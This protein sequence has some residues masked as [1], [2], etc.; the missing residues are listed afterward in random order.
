[1]TSRTSPAGRLVIQ[2]GALLRRDGVS[3][4]GYVVIE[5]DR[6][7]EVAPGHHRS[8]DVTWA[9]GLLAP[10]FIDLQINGGAGCDFLAPSGEELAAAHTYLRRTG[11]VAYLPTLI[12]APDDRLRAALAFFAER[13]QE[14]D[15]PRI[16]GV[17]L[18]GPFL[19]RARPGAHRPAYLRTPSVEWIGRLLEEFQGLIRVVTLAPELDG[20]LDV[21]DHLVARGVVVAVGHT[22]ATF[23]EAMA[24]FDRGARLATHL[25]NAMRPYHH[26]EPGIVGAALLHP[27]V[28]CSLIAD[29]VHLHPAVLQ[30]VVAIKTTHH[31]A[32]VT[33]AIA[34][35]GAS[36]SS[37]TLGDQ[38]VTVRDGAPRLPDGTLAGS[39]LSMD[40]AVRNLCS[41]GVPSADALQMATTVPARLL[42]VSDAALAPGHRADLV[43]LDG[44]MQVTTTV[45]AGRIV[46][47]R[48]G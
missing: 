12:S 28:T 30:Q 40:Q 19:S 3:G 10:G 41:L 31:T 6:I 2:A 26:R 21:I 16:L 36:A 38:P 24:A 37:V 43:V 45:L 39:V 5:G 4:P 15:A 33:D 27:E 13:A 18:E 22:D 7:T 14:L 46:F 29:L 35:A 34:A 9:D 11:T 44:T 1:M 8:P 48:T 20:A 25:F 42:G 17:H 32:L 47:H 23:A